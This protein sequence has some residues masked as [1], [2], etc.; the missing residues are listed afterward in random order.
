VTL[1]AAHENVRLL[2]VHEDPT[3][4]LF[5]KRTLEAATWADV[6]GAR[7]PAQAFDRIAATADPVHVVLLHWSLPEMGALMLMSTLD[8]LRERR[9]KVFAFTT[10]WTEDELA[11]ALQSGVDALLSAPLTLEAVAIE[12]QSLR[13]RGEALSRSRLLSLAGPRLMRRDD[14]LWHIAP[15]DIWR[16]RMAE[17][18]GRVHSRAVEAQGRD[19]EALLD[20]LDRLYGRPIGADVVKLLRQQLDTPTIGTE[21]LV[22][23]TGLPASRVRAFLSVLETL[24]ASGHAKVPYISAARAAVGYVQ[25]VVANR[26]EVQP[27][28]PSGWARVQMLAAELLADGSTAAHRAEVLQRVVA[29]MAQVPVSAIT[30]LPEGTRRA[31]IASAVVADDQL[32]LVDRARLE[33]LNAVLQGLPETPIDTERLRCLCAAL[34]ATKP[35]DP[36]APARLVGVLV[37]A[38]AEDIEVDTERLKALETALRALPPMDDVDTAALVA[39]LGILRASLEPGAEA[40]LRRVERLVDHWAEGRTERV[41]VAVL[42]AVVRAAARAHDR[43]RPEPI[44]ERL[45]AMVGAADYAAQGRAFDACDG[46]RRLRPAV[47][48]DTD[49]LRHVLRR[50]V[51][52]DAAVT[53]ERLRALLNEADLVVSMERAA[54]GRSGELAPTRENEA[55][56]LAQLR[57]LALSL[58]VPLERLHLTPDEIERL[59]AQ[60]ATTDDT[61]LAGLSPEAILRLRALAFVL[62][63][64]GRDAPGLVVRSLE[65]GGRDI[66]AI[67]GLAVM[68]EAPSQ[69]GARAAL[70]EALGLSD[71]RVGAAEIERLIAS[72]HLEAAALGLGDL[73]D[74]DPRAPNLLNEVALALRNA[75]RG[76]E[77]EPLFMRALAIQ[78]NR[79]NLLFNCGRMYLEAGRLAQAV[80]PLETAVTLAPDFL[81]AAKALSEAKRGLSSPSE[82]R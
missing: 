56:V 78:P 5:V 16:R 25:S 27:L 2:V 80:A 17:L 72:G 14:R 57:A 47:V 69:A 77:G 53:P 20:R 58:D 34:G 11:R 12:V 24:Y 18:A 4:V 54:V 8:D 49:R 70:R 68:L 43:L 61:A 23:A 74:R 81:L 22:K 40:D 7:A 32:A 36:G 67:G 41:G 76:A 9:P 64:A 1:P 44:I 37:D 62:G 29:E 3:M 52:E 51:G 73:N 59:A 82:G 45:H 30:A 39:R 66:R 71:A 75:N 19:G 55:R 31:L 28:S 48:S 46:L 15:D 79:L 60:F 33:V 35:P 65:R 42:G 26:I 10:H 21:A 13:S 38:V 50:V 6:T 63:R